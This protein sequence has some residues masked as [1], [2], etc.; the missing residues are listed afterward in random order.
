M[1]SYGIGSTR[2]VSF[3]ISSY[4]KAKIFLRLAVMAVSFVI[5]MVF[6]DHGLDVCF[7]KVDTH[8]RNSV[9]F[10]VL[11]HEREGYA[12]LGNQNSPT[13]PNAGPPQRVFIDKIRWANT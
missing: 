1:S 9:D 11:L 13:L 5:F 7:N 6:C 10:F 12:F 3:S 8:E 4:L 2:V